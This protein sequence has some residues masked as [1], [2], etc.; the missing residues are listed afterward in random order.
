[1]RPPSSLICCVVVL[2]ITDC[3][4][5][6]FEHNK[7]SNRAEGISFNSHTIGFA[8]CLGAYYTGQYM[9][10]EILSNSNV[11]AF[12]RMSYRWFLIVL[13]AAV[14]GCLAMIAPLIAG[15]AMPCHP[16]GCI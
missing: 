2:S 1:M 13:K 16:A 8:V 12:L 9:R 10:K 5:Y 15:D 3:H 4:V 14:L 6:G 11:I 7:S